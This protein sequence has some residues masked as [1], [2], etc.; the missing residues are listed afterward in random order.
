MAKRFVSIWFRHLTTDWL[1]IRRPVLKGQPVVFAESDHGR[2]V[3]TATN[4]A[5]ETQGIGQGMAVADARAVVMDLQVFD[6]K[7]GRNEMLLKALGEWCIR[8][9]PI[10]AVYLPCGLILDASGCTHLW[11]GERE[12][13][14]SIVKRLSQKGYDVRV[15]IA[16]T[17]GAAWAN[18]CFGRVSPIIEPGKQRD[19][20]RAI[21]SVGLRLEPEILDKLHKLGLYYIGD[22]MDMARPVLRRRFGYGLLHRIS[23]A[24]GHE[25]EVIE[26]L[27]PVQVYESRLPCLEPIRTRTAIEIAVKKLLEMLCLDLKSDGHGIRTAV[28]KCF[29]LDGR[30]EQVDIGTNRPTYHISHLFKLFE[31]K[32]GSI[33]PGLGIELFI[34]TATKTEDVPLI[35]EAAWAGKQG[36]DDSAIAEMLDRV[37]GKVGAKVI[38]RYLP[39]EHFWP[40]RSIKEASTLK[41]KPAI[42]WLQNHPGPAHL[43]NVPERVNVIF[44]EPDNPPRTFIHHAKRYN[45]KKADGPERIEREWWMDEGEHRDYYVVEDEKGCRYWLFRL[46]YYSDE[47]HYQWFIHGF[48][49]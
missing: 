5:A 15:S 24:L 32:I 35:Q 30:V 19:V 10:V 16:D 38:H 47:K 1:T 23:Q 33:A 8:Y 12:Y 31:L 14:K 28:L 36:L 41:E 46:G 20:L 2:M 42:P 45:I 39:N 26:P 13:L 48:F 6:E 11:G 22:F 27:H 17:V 18:V 37:A 44:I 49:A 34:L 43:L 3:I 40:E 9:S 4:A 21:P 25:E 7:P 29:R